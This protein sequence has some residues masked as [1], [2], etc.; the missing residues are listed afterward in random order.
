MSSRSAVCTHPSR[1]ESRRALLSGVPCRTLAARYALSPSALCRHT[2]HLA[3]SPEAMQHHQDR[4][5]RGPSWTSSTS[6]RPA[7]T[8]CSTKPRIP[9]P[10]Y[11]SGLRP[12]VS[13]GH[14]APGKML[15]PP[16]GL[17]GIF[18]FRNSSGSMR[19]SSGM[20][21]AFP[22]NLPVTCGTVAVPSDPLSRFVPGS[23]SPLRPPKPQAGMTR[24]STR[25]RTIPAFSGTGFFY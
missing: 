8:A 3:R 13:P 23:P 10:P 21:A 2:R 14:R 16:T 6:W 7:S 24:A 19:K 18:L 15:C 4:P 25:P 5:S 9:Y 11:R 1:E 12:G 17:T 20:L 22:E